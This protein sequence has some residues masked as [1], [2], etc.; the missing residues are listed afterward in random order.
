M[1]G[2][3]PSSRCDLFAFISRQL[4]YLPET[5]GSDHLILTSDSSFADR[6]V[7]WIPYGYLLRAPREL[8]K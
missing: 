5:I 7:H 3:L 1:D 4:I 8:E 6:A 2:G